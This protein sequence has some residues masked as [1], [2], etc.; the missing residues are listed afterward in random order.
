MGTPVAYGSSWAR[1][2]ITVAAANLCH[3]HSNATS[4]T[5]RARPGINPESSWLLV[6]F[7][8]AEP[9]WEVPNQMI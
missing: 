8:T 4:L 2:Y 3:S 9:Q 1:G 7:L 5:H 6:R